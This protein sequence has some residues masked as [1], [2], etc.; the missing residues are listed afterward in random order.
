MLVM[1]M[2]CDDVAPTSPTKSSICRRTVWGGRATEDEDREK[3][4][5]KCRFCR[6]TVW[7]GPKQYCNRAH[8]KFF[9]VTALRTVRNICSNTFFIFFVFIHSLIRFS[10]F[11]KRYAKK[12]IIRLDPLTLIRLSCIVIFSIHWLCMTF[13]RTRKNMHVNKSGGFYQQ[14]A[15]YDYSKYLSIIHKYQQLLESEGSCD[16]RA[17]ANETGVSSNTVLK[18]I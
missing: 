9:Q 6:A 14:D 8:S 17:L 7:G 5:I 2:K 16:S 15:A 11:P 10:V 4:S 1:N 3:N 13:I 12:V 18:S